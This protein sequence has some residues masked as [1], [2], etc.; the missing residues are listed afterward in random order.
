[1]LIINIL[2]FLLI[3]CSNSKGHRGVSENIAESRK[4]NV[5]ISE[6]E[7]AQNPFRINDTLSLKVN[8]IW[9]EKQWAYGDEETET[10]ISEGYQMVILTDTDL[11]SYSS[12]WLIGVN[13][14][15]YFRTCG[16]KCLMSDFKTRVKDLEEWEVQ[17]SWKLDSSSKKDVIGR[18][19]VRKK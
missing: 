18:F 3:S 8:K 7:I 15:R 4:R 10:I 9:V 5:F 11:K 1:M 19:K 14:D 2:I 6:Y 17:N 16:T 12:T 13:G